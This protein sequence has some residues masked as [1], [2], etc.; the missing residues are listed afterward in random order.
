M[1][2]FKRGNSSFS[3]HWTEEH[4]DVLKYI[5]SV[6]GEEPKRVSISFHGD[7]EVN[8]SIIEIKSCLEHNRIGKH[9]R[10]GKPT[11]RRGMFHFKGH[12]KASDYI[13]FILIRDSGKMA[14]ALYERQD[15]PNI[16]KPF[17][18]PWIKIF[19]GE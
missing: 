13:L 5:Q 18:L 9:W 19:G 4:P 3:H 12:E 16:G 2:P 17:R 1:K 7:I 8:G 15:F 10:T 14:F 6:F 11:T